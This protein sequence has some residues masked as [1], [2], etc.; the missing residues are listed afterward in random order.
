MGSSSLRPL[1]RPAL[2]CLQLGRAVSVRSADRTE[3]SVAPLRRR[4]LAQRTGLLVELEPRSFELLDD[5]LGQL[6]PGSRS[7]N[8]IGK[9]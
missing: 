4:A 3:L 5:P 7:G 1:C 2:D 6:A 9:R 8:Q